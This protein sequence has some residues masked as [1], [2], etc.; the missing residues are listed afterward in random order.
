MVTIEPGLYFI[1]TLMDQ[2]RAAGLHQDFIDFGRLESFREF[3]GLRLEE[4]F[5]INTTEVEALRG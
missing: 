1:P 3:G 2:W 4:D 5:L